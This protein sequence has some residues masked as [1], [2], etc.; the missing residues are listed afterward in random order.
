MK[1]HTRGDLCI[2][3]G[4]VHVLFLSINKL[5]TLI[6]LDGEMFR[7]SGIDS[8]ISPSNIQYIRS[9]LALGSWSTFHRP[10]TC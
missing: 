1:V 2:Q 3:N 5:Y 8:V 4:F 9:I 10:Y 7:T 6:K